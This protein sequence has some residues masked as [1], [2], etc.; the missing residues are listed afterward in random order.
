[1]VEQESTYSGL[2]V[3]KSVGTE[4]LVNFPNLSWLN[5]V[6]KILSTIL[7]SLIIIFKAIRN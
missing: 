7:N 6:S 4:R 5:M 3:I 1:M 2:A